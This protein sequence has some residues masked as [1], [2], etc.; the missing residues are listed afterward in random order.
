MV[1]GDTGLILANSSFK[2][3]YTVRYANSWVVKEIQTNLDHAGKHF[4]W[5]I[6]VK[7]PEQIKT[8]M[9]LV[10][11]SMDAIDT[12][13]E[14]LGR[15]YTNQENLS[16][17]K[18]EWA[19]YREM[20]YEIVEYMEAGEIVKAIT[21]YTTTYEDL[22]N[23]LHSVLSTIGTETDKDAAFGYQQIRIM[24]IVFSVIMLIGFIVSIL[25]SANFEKLLSDVITKPI[26]ELKEVSEKLADGDL[27]VEVT[28]ESEDELGVLANS[29]RKTCTALKDIVGDLSYVLENLRNGDYTVS[30]KNEAVYVGDFKQIIDDLNTMVGK[31]SEALSQI[32]LSASQV[33]TG[34]EQMSRGASDIAE[35]ATEQ[36]SA[37]EELTATIESVS[38]IAESSAE[39]AIAATSTV[40]N[41]VVA[42]ERG[43]EEVK[44]LVN[45]MERITETSKEIENII[46]AIE[47]IASQTNLLSLNAS[48]EAARAGEAGR[49]F[50]VVA[51]QIGK[52]ANESADSAVKTR[53]KISKALT[54]IQ[55][56]SQIVENTTTIITKTIEDMESFET[57]VTEIAKASS[58]QTE[59]VKQIQDGVEQIS[60][61]VQNNSAAAEE[62]S[63][64]SE[65]LS[66][67]AEGLN[68]LTSQFKLR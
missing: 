17:L 33:A 2:K 50:A 40:K 45:A 64:V 5:S 6:S 18:T 24:V 60:V 25:V 39:S 3:F 58:D 12:Y 30:S 22:T 14:E 13:I 27:N 37:V 26:V 43:R 51:E 52:L 56:G 23:D 47:D 32:N 42:A 29:F 38:T 8:H 21:L 67:Q 55:R 48:I 62:T 68:N 53:E 1:I 49:G 59:M 44:E 9:A 11:G 54:E 15:A 19:D 34:S 41:A 61:V 20:F 28:Y 7:D 57:V 35:G 36:A 4:L 63:A 16:K 46:D 31:Q 65:E 66:A 10:N